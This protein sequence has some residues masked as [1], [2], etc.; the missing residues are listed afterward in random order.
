[1]KKQC[2]TINVLRLVLAACAMVLGAGYSLAQESIACPNMKEAQCI[3]IKVRYYADRKV[4]LVHPKTDQPF[5]TCTLGKDCKA[6]G[7]QLDLRS[8]ELMQFRR[9]S[10]CYRICSGGSCYDRCP[11]H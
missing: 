8:V 2:S 5:K 4:E 10:H 9:N 3:E 11:A 6:Y 1:M 7:A